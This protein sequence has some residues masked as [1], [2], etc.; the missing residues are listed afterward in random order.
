MAW[1]KENAGNGFINSDTS[2]RA[3]VSPSGGTYYVRIGTVALAPGYA[4][5]QEAID[6]MVNI[7]NGVTPV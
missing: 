5:E 3:S 6:A 4:T 1:L 2:I 7:L